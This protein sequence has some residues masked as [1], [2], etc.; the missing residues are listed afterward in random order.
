MPAITND[1][2]ESYKVF[3][4]SGVIKKDNDLIFARCDLSAVQIKILSVILGQI[5]KDDDEL[6]PLSLSSR[7]FVNQRYLSF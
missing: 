1:E 4:N 3:K 5:Y 6:K 2:L 7:F